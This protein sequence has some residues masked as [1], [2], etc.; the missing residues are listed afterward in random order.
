MYDA[1]DRACN[2]WSLVSLPHSY[3][4]RESDLPIAICN[5]K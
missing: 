1:C 5:E 4:I 3:V 2:S